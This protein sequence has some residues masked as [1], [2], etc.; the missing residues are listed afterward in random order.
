[1]APDDGAPA[2][3]PSA[4]LTG[5]DPVGV[6]L[7]AAGLASRML[8]RGV[9]ALPSA[10]GLAVEVA[11]EALS[12]VG[13]GAP[14]PRLVEAVVKGALDHLVGHPG[15]VP[16][17]PGLTPGD[18]FEGEELRSDDL[19]EE[20]WIEGVPLGEL[21]ALAGALRRPARLAAMLVLAAGLDPV[22]AAHLTGRGVTSLREDLHQVGR[23]W[24]DRRLLGVDPDVPIP[25]PLPDEP[26]ADL[27]APAADRREALVMLA[28]SAPVLDADRA[29]AGMVTRASR[30]RRNRRSTAAALVAASVLVPLVAIG[31]RDDR[32]PISIEAADAPPRASTSTTVTTT[33][34]VPVT[35]AEA[36]PIA[37]V[38][39]AQ[40]VLVAPPTA[41]PT[42]APETIPPPTN[43]PLTATLEVLTPI[44]EAGRTAVAR[45]VWSDPD[46]AEPLR[47]VGIWGD[48]EVFYSV[49]AD[50]QPGCE[51]PG[52]GG[53]GAE[54]LRFR[55]AT[56]GTYTVSVSVTSCDG[57]GTFG[58]RVTLSGRIQV[59][60]PI[61]RDQPGRTVVV[62]VTGTLDAESAVA[63]LTP[64][65][66]AP[67]QL[68]ARNPPLP[69]TASG[70]PTDTGVP[71]VLRM[72][73]G[74]RGE[75]RLGEGEACRRGTVDLTV[76]A[77]RVL[78]LVLSDPC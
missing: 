12:R 19:E 18:L 48:P 15:R 72:P 64:E 73:D 37:P 13:T 34:T 58:E 74:V 41:P 67:V 3:A 60:P 32:A 30:R 46:L 43:T 76:S 9:P 62:A 70:M 75:L 33:T 45:V 23:R 49:P 2:P 59:L 55:Y 47:F 52:T 7:V 50:L 44:V 17:P 26:E 53:S 10:D 5:R 29:L 22:S 28:A 68:E 16:V 35:V 4:Q 69:L 25:P 38:T 78:R 63:I 66:G 39:T 8:G 56:P 71:T 54:E 31:L 21:G 24:V 40:P 77:P 20:L 42:T 1:M 57:N 61:V 14:T 36:V 65:G 51:S 27:P 11:T 6:V